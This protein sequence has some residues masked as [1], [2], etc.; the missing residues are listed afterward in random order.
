MVQCFELL[1]HVDRGLKFAGSEVMLVDQPQNSTVCVGSQ[2]R[3]DCTYTGTSATPSWRINSTIYTSFGLPPHHIFNGRALIVDVVFLQDN[4][5]TYQCFFELFVNGT[6]LCVVQSTIG[7]LTVLETGRFTINKYHHSTLICN[8]LNQDLLHV[9]YMLVQKT[10]PEWKEKLISLF[11]AQY[12]A[13][14][15]QYGR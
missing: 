1:Y 13:L 12:L 2:A 5:K 11:L 15:L 10:L 3:M 8:Y 6:G 7:K 4:G 14:F 9:N